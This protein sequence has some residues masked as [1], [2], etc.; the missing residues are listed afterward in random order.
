MDENTIVLDNASLFRDLDQAVLQLAELISLYEHRSI[1]M[2][3]ICQDAMPVASQIAG[4]LGLTLV[5]SAVD[6]NTETAEFQRKNNPVDFDYDIVRESGRDVPQNFIIHQQQNLRMNLKSIYAVT[7]E[8]MIKIYPDKLIILVDQLT[9]INATFFPC[10]TQNHADQSTGNSFSIPAIRKFIFLHVS[11]EKS[12]NSATQGCD[13]IIE[14]T[15][16][17]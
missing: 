11:D 13:I 15:F 2:V 5:F 12:G 16:I 1:L 10:L 3:V 8:A 4:K 6:L 7:Y 14:H 9:N 17:E